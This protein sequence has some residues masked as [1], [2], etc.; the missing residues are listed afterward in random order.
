MGC[1]SC[2]GGLAGTDDG[3]AAALV[4]GAAEVPPGEVGVAVVVAPAVVLG[5]AFGLALLAAG[6]AEGAAELVV[7]DGLGGPKQPVRTIRPLSP[8]TLSAESLGLV[9]MPP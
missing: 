4:V 6:L 8:R 2:A 5:V 1:G 3:G 7:G 9:M